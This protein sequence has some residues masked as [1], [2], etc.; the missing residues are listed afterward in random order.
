MRSRAL[1]QT[2]AAFFC[3]YILR[4]LSSSTSEPHSLNSFV[5]GSA[6]GTLVEFSSVDQAAR[7]P[8]GVK[9]APGRGVVPAGQGSGG[10][11]S[12]TWDFVEYIPSPLE[13]DWQRDIARIQDRVCEESISR[14]YPAL[15]G[16]WL[17]ATAAAQKPKNA[18][19]PSLTSSTVEP[20]RHSGIIGRPVQPSE[21]PELYSIFSAF[22]YQ[23]RFGVATRTVLDPFRQRFTRS[24]SQTIDHNL[25]YGCV[26]GA[27]PGAL[28]GPTC[29]SWMPVPQWVQWCTFPSSLWPGPS[30]TPGCAPLTKLLT[31]STETT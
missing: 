30:V 21:N 7:R 1:L 20:A 11:S 23:L 18:C 16:V 15:E 5:G 29:R 25:V 24:R 14:I 31:C 28:Q 6:A 22:V 4:Y 19:I 9:E 3:G 26:V 13:A 10:E 27:R 12:C 17:A 8:V 2:A